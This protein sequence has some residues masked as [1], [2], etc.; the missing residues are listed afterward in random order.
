[1]YILILFMCDGNVDCQGDMPSH[2]MGCTCNNSIPYSIQ[3]KY[4]HDSSGSHR[5]SMFY[6]TNRE[7]TCQFY[8]F[9]N[10]T[11]EKQF[12]KN[13]SF[14]NILQNES[15][16]RHV[17]DTRHKLFNDLLYYELKTKAP[18]FLCANGT[19]ILSSLVNDLVADCDR[20]EDEYL[21]IYLTKGNNYF[22]CSEKNQ[23]PCRQGHPK[24]Y[25]ISEICNYNINTRNHL[26]PCRTGEHLHKCENFECNMMFKCPEFYCIPWSYLCDGK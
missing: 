15:D 8:N 24:C 21:L 16:F 9:L 6:I 22:Q 11:V 20:A 12:G 5:C 19:R 4:L 13:T 7:G 3:C 14:S 1:M 2:E 25:E 10:S 18:S 23:L 17:I 26:Y